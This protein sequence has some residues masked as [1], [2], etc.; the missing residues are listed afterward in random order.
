MTP[1]TL[2]L[3][4][5]S[6]LGACRVAPPAQ[7]QRSAGTLHYVGSST[8]AVFVRSAEPVYGAVKFELDT[9]PESAGG[10]QAIVAGEA[11]L[12]GIA[13]VPE[14]ATLEAGV[15][16]TLVGRDAIAVI[17]NA[18]NP[19]SDLS[20]ADLGRIF[21]GELQ[22][23]RELGGPDLEIEPYI[24]GPDSATR[25]VF[26]AAFVVGSMHRCMAAPRRPE[27][28]PAA[29]CRVGI[30]YRYLPPNGCRTHSLTQA[31]R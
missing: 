12:A 21:S 3:F 17:V 19:V 15:I 25:R 20:R 13:R 7:D 6:L 18:K 11:D 31:A 10:E 22:N 1:R 4:L 26:A 30:A 14:E 5:L 8:V 29:D 28:P 23:W 9:Q 2:L 24:V 16:A 27:A